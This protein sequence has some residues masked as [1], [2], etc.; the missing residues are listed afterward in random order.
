[1]ISRS[2]YFWS[3]SFL[4][5]E[6][7]FTITYFFLLPSFFLLFAL[8]FFVFLHCVSLSF[9]RL[10]YIL[11]IIAFIPRPIKN[12]RFPLFLHVLDRCFKTSNRKN[13]TQVDRPFQITSALFF[14]F[15]HVEFI[16][17]SFSYNVIYS[18]IVLKY[19]QLSGV[20]PGSSVL[21]SSCLG[22]KWVKIIDFR[23]FVSLILITFYFHRRLLNVR[24]VTVNLFFFNKK[25]NQFT[26]FF[27]MIKS[28]LK[29]FFLSFDI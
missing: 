25:Q 24:G 9:S 3:K 20:D 2:P 27:N 12:I 1:M 8:Y 14:L 6:H 22:S 11:I 18:K 19:S 17:F 4:Q 23:S 15:S 29:N 21:P 16:F 13:L 28:L 10:H 5:V 26:V 7:S